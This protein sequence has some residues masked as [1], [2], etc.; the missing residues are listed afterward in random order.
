MP[1][2]HASAGGL[3]PVRPTG[4]RGPAGIAA[5]SVRLTRVTGGLANISGAPGGR[6][7]PAWAAGI[8]RWPGDPSRLPGP[9]PVHRVSDCVCPGA[10]P[11]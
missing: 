11:A 3:Q 4:I 2:A 7:G 9:G 8:A 1:G 10:A 6:Q 5:P